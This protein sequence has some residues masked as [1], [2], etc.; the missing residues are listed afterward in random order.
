M[1]LSRHEPK[2]YLPRVAP[3]FYQST[4]VIF[5]THTIEDRRT[6]WL[7]PTFH[8]A[9]REIVL[10][11]A[12]REQLLCP[13][14]TLMP[15]HLHLVWM[16]V[17]PTSNQRRASSFLRQRL[18]PL[19]EPNRFQHQAHDHVLREQERKRNTFSATCTYIAENPVRAGLAADRSAWDYTGCIVPGYVDLYPLQP[20]YWGKFWRIYAAAMGR[21]G[22]GKIATP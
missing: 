19:L 14:Y 8:Q 2:G 21:G 10:H 20:D 17:S 11:A 22:I 15:D 12:I 6:G 7:N 1:P 16:G 3:E 5:W 18:I 13:I 4:A 9:F